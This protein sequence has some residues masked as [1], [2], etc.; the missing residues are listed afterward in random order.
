VVVPNGNWQ[1]TNP[2]GSTS[3]VQTSAD[4]SVTS[5]GHDTDGTVTSFTVNADG[6]SDTSTQTSPDGSS[7]T[8]VNDAIGHT[9]TNTNPDGSSTSTETWSDGTVIASQQ[10]ADGSGTTSDLAEA[11]GVPRNICGLSVR[12]QIGHKPRARFAE[13]NSEFRHDEDFYADSRA[14]DYSLAQALPCADAPGGRHVF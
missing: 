5:T 9:V 10:N 6:S 1:Q 3:S 7:T 8:E 2:D 11:M 4:G 14:A 12:A 13:S